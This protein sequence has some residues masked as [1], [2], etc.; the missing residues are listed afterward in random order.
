[1]LEIIAETVADA[2]AAQE[3]GAAQLD[4]ECSFLQ[5]GLTPSA[6]LI[7]QVCAR[8]GIDVLPLIRPHAHDEGFC[9]TQDDVAVMCSDIAQARTLGADGFL[10]GCL[11]ADGQVDLEAMKAL[12]DAAAGRPLHFHIAW[13]LTA[14]P[15]R[16]LEAMIELGVQSV[17]ITGHAS[18]RAAPGAAR[19]EADHPIMSAEPSAHRARTEQQMERIRTFVRQAQGRI[20]FVIVGGVNA[21]NCRQ[22][23]LGTGVA[24]LHS[25]SGVRE[26]PTRH[27]VVSAVKIAQLARELERAEAELRAR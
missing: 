26:P 25:G 19:G 16:A 27:G 15:L 7:E 3:G 12:R 8:V 23:V 20:D 21:D 18:P 13:E 22:I 24:H 11:T 1:M 5:G 4:L 9:Y 17:R 10:V 2:L 6:G 14:D